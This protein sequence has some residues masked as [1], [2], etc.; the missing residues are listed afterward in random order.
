MASDN[1]LS[2]AFMLPATMS[3]LGHKQ[4]NGRGLISTFVRF[5]PKA[6]KRERDWIVRFVPL[7]TDA[8][9]Q[10]TFLIRSPRRRGRAAWAAQREQKERPV[11][12]FRISGFHQ[13]F[14]LQEFGT[15]LHPNAW[16]ICRKLPEQRT[17]APDHST[18]Y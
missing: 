12:A 6:D 1:E 11:A 10:I 13:P 5:S 14:R 9:Q 8:P 2:V 16:R 18:R 7:A 15:I 4:T 17:A 3:V